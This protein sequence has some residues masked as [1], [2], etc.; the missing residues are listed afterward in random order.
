MVNGEKQPMVVNSKLERRVSNPKTKG[1]T[2]TFK[3]SE[4]EEVA[5]FSV[6]KLTVEIGIYGSTIRVLSCKNDVVVTR[7]PEGC[8]SDMAEINVV[9][10]EITTET[11]ARVFRV[12]IVHPDEA[13]TELGQVMQN[14]VGSAI[15]GLKEETHSVSSY[16]VCE[17][18][19]V[20]SISSP[21]TA[22]SGVAKNHPLP[23]GYLRV[24]KTITRVG[25]TKVT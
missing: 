16:Q 25:S 23:I 14:E 8:L 11:R 18:M 13:S 24:G 4:K 1:K 22:N 21:I 19:Q 5:F 15:T 10:L 3:N 6:D 12:A 7:M 17:G 9:S 2:A 20:V